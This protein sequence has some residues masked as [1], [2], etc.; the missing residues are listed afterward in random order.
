[1]AKG[2]KRI[3]LPGVVIFLS[4]AIL[5][6]HYTGT[7]CTKTCVVDGNDMGFSP[8]H[9]SDQGYSNRKSTKGD[10]SRP[11]NPTGVGLHDVGN[12]ELLIDDVG[13]AEGW[14]YTH[15]WPKVMSIDHLY[16]NWLA[17]GYS[18]SN[19]SD[20]WD[21]DW[22]TT[23]GGGMVITEPGVV[24]DEE[25]YAQYRDTTN[26]IEVTQESYAWA[27]PP[28]DDYVIIKYTIKNI[29]A[30]VL[31]TLFV[32]HRS[33]F[34]V[35]GD[36]GGAPTD[37]SSFDGTR[38]LAY[39]WDVLSTWHVG[40]KLLRGN[41][42]GYHQGWYASSDPEKFYALST[43]GAD[44]PTPYP[45]D[46]CFWLS[47]GSYAFLPGESAIVAFAFLAG[48]DLS[49]FLA[50]AD[51]AQARW[52]SL[53][54]A[55]EAVHGNPVAPYELNPHP[56]PFRDKTFIRYSVPSSGDV[57]IV[58][59]NPLGQDVRMLVEKRENAGI[60]TVAWD[61]RN[62]AGELVPAGVY[63]VR[64]RTGEHSTTRK[65]VVLR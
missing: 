22:V 34:D 61:G 13:G 32:G 50:N 53:G 59:Y 39:M 3:S 55:E 33:D 15:I 5:L 64:F 24:A 10:I 27:D 54:I 8:Q 40:V 12:I 48:E 30:S 19:V 16:W 41:Y 44:P 57:N 31:L 17:I 38:D 43:P 28:H 4:V 65:L 51:A 45:D 7:R 29:G 42:R 6:A 62:H 2:C 9:C 35:L 63:F 26:G 47:A 14:R 21:G 46:W 18:D 11:L 37:M 56:N 20:G 49:D 60:R 1:M 23:P 52:D 36:H 25:G 58:I